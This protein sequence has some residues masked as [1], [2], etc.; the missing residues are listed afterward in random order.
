[1]K[2]THLLAPALA[3]LAALS[4]LV[5]ASSAPS[6][7]GG[8][9]DWTRITQSEDPHDEMVRLFQQIE[10]RQ[11]Q[12]DTLLG[13]ARDRSQSGQPHLSELLKDTESYAHDVTR[14]IDRIL[15][16]AGHSHP[17]GGGT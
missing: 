13:R 2:L 10:R 7:D 3:A 9:V 1:M 15:E 8:R 4:T 14:D 12:I 17:G 16:L 11:S 5:P 6:R